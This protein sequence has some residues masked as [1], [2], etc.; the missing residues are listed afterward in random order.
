MTNGTL[1]LVDVLFQEAYT[2]PPLVEPLEI[3]NQGQKP[4]FRC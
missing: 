2:W 1:A 3:T 4:K